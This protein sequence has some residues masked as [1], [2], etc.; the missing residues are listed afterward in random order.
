MVPATSWFMV[1]TCASHWATLAVARR[2]GT[3]IAVAA[4]MQDC[5]WSVAWC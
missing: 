5:S 2:S 4:S 1:L 3:F